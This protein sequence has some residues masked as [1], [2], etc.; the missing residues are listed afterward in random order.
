MKIGIIGNGFVGKA[1]SSIKCQDINILIYD[2]N[3]E[4]CNPK[5]ITIDQL[6]VCEIIFISVPTP[7]NNDGSCYTKIIQDVLVELKTNNFKNHIVL[8]STIPPGLSDKLDCFF[9]PE[10]LTEKNYKIDFYNNKDWIF[11]LKENNKLNNDNFIK[12][13]QKLFYLAYT[14]NK[15]K[16]NNLHFVSNKEAETIKLFR[17]CFLATKISFCNEFYQYC[18]ANDINYDNMIKLA[19][20][21]NRIGHSHTNVPGHDGNKGFGGTCFPKDIS[22]MQY[23]MNKCNVPSYIIDSV[24]NRNTHIDRKNKDWENNK[25]RSVL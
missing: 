22:S 14:N 9:M 3:P 13:I 5:N 17:N 19:A 15:I 23:E 4:L 10:F 8:R 7:M 12:S 20:N 6:N 21:D 2:L 16:N 11:G 25:G 24:I 18:I 1:F